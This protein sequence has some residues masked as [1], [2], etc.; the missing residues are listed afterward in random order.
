MRH[1]LKCTLCKSYGLAEGCSCG[2]RRVSP[3]PA[4]F[5]PND[6]YAHY[7][8]IAKK[9]I[10]DNICSGSEVSLDPDNPDSLDNPDTPYNPYNSLKNA[11]E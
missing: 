11:K 7:R 3:R 9:M 8:R 2:S 10:E 4:R 6:K 5:I 1:I